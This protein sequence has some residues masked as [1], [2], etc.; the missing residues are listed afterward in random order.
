MDAFASACRGRLRY[1]RY[2]ESDLEC[3]RCPVLDLI[4]TKVVSWM[5]LS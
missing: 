2:L 4:E 3:P 5:E 1:G